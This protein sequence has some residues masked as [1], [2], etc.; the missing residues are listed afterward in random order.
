VPQHARATPKGK[1]TRMNRLIAGRVPQ[2]RGR[3]P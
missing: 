2:L 1:A 3:V